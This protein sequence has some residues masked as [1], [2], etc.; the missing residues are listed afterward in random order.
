MSKIENEKTQEYWQ[1]V[2]NKVLDPKALDKE[3]PDGE[4]DSFSVEK[5][6]RSFLKIMG[7]SVTALPLTGCIKIPVKKALPYLH[8]NDTVI[9]GVA[10]WYASTWKGTPILVKTR[11]SRPIKIEG[12]DKS[13][14]TMGGVDSQGQ[15]SVL[16]LY[17]S[18]RFNG[19]Q[20]AGKSVEWDQ[21]DKSL[22]AD[23]AKATESGREFYI[24]T[25]G[26]N[27]PSEL[28]L[29]KEFSSKFGAK[30][31]SY[32][33]TSQYSTAKANE[34]SFGTLA[35]TEYDFEKANVIVS[36]EADFMGTWG[37]T[38]ANTKQFSSRRNPKHA[39]GMNKLIQIEPSMSLTGSN[40]D[41][42]YTRSTEETRNVLLSVL[43]G[44]T[45]EGNTKATDINVDV[46]AGI[47]KELKANAGKSLVISGDRDINAQVVVNKINQALG[48]YGTTLNVVNKKYSSV[49]NDAD[50]NSFVTSMNSGKVGVA[51]FINTNPAYD[52]FDSAKITSGIAK[53]AT[54]VSFALSADETS[55]LC[56][57]VAASNH[58]Y[59]S[60]SDTQVSK[61]ELSF[62]Q[63]VIQPLFGTRMFSETLMSLM[64]TSGTFHEY[65][66][67][68]WAKNFFT[69]QSALATATDF[70]NKSLHDGVVS[71]DGLSSVVNASSFSATSAATKLAAVKYATGLNIITYRKSTTKDG[72]MANN[73]WLQECP[74]PITKATWDNY[75]MV[76]PAYAKENGI[77][78]GDVVTVK[79]AT[80]TV[81]IPAIVQ[82]GTAKNTIAVAVGYG[83]KV[84]GKVA[85]NLGANAFGFNSFV[86]GSI[87]NNTSF[88]SITKTGKFK[89]LA[90]TQT[91]HS[92]EGR[93]IVR[94]TTFVDYAKKENA[95]NEKKAKLVH[96]YPAHKKDGHQ[97][98]MSVDLT[99][100]TGCSSCV[101]SCNAENNISVVGREEVANRR[102]MHWMR[103]DRYYKGDENQP[104]VM[105]M[106]ML[107]QHCDNAPCENVCPVMAT[108]QSSDGLN[109]QTYN[110]CVGTRYCA[111]N[112]PYK[113]RRFNW[114]NYDRSDK[115]ANMVL[116]PDV[117]SRTRG[118]MEK[119]SMCVQ[120]IQEGKLLAKK[121]RRLLKDGDIKLACQQSCPADAIVFGDMNDKS[122][123]ISAY[124]GNERN[125]TVLE[126]LNVQPRVS[127]LTK[128][129]NK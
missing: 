123:N 83:R 29:I 109:Q 108:T 111:N 17:D 124:L 27:S 15:A 117:S 34:M 51:F 7:F 39:M 48:N 98:A 65:M 4:F 90:Q 9:P 115:L 61:S 82:P 49:A 71:L 101:I 80:H 127:Y 31:I 36:F 50:F 19:P 41:Y 119:C 74:D 43:K 72:D 94:E 89:G 107:C 46:V 20:M 26:L 73:P 129:R 102:E 14:F 13:T 97:W 95:G 125:Y 23:I 28:S 118:I 56:N 113:V 93:D 12:N 52:Y 116:N 10:N 87:H 24:V 44:I 3:F 122:S 40:A 103:L 114:F 57:Y 69:K 62:T 58:N 105:H 99:S 37:N 85:K 33:P 84:A 68:V 35:S 47:I 32:E 86:H 25:P 78:S 64:G 55:S 45:G 66:K 18:N 1:D 77:K 126:E 104:E 91:H 67:G 5:S 92:M 121:D 54:S 2:E 38:V 128:I 70:W 30:H 100:C 59:E 88:G 106:P 81:T 22:V 16:S 53:V 8:K 75:A 11:E 60:W 96:I 76:S 63:P 6:R 112:C 42:R 110:R 21:F 79:S 120:R